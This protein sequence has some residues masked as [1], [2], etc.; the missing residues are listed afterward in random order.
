MVELVRQH[1]QIDFG[2]LKG[3]LPRKKVVPTDIDG[4]LE[5]NGSFLYIETKFSMYSMPLGQRL[6]LQALSKLD[7]FTV[8]CVHIEK[9][10]TSVD[11]VYEFAPKHMCFV[12]KG[13]FTKWKECDLDSF[14]AFY[15]GWYDAVKS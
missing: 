9:K 14:V 11:G 8:C 7:C 5:I 10:Q 12:N 13:R 15:K 1:V 6:T 3:V 2:P 4:L